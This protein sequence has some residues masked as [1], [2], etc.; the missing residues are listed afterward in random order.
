MIQRLHN[1]PHIMKLT[2]QDLGAGVCLHH[3]IIARMHV[4]QA[5]ET[6]Y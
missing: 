1:G 2:L 4:G 3:L 5:E 6:S